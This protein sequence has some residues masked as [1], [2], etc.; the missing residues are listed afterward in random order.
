[1]RSVVWSVVIMLGL[2]GC[3][4][5]KTEPVDGRVKKLLRQMTLEE[6][7]GQ[8]T[9]VTLQ[10]V[11]RT[12]GT[13]GQKHAIDPVKLEEAITQYHVGSILNVWDVAHSLEYWQELITQMQDLATQ[14][15]RL[16]IPIIYGIDAIH[17]A[18]YTLGA[19]LFPQSIAMAATWNPELVRQCAAVTAL[20]VRASGIAWNFNPVMDLGRQPLWPR[21]WET[22]GEDVY[23]AQIMGASYVQGLQGDNIANPEKVAACPKHFL[24]YSFPLT[25]KDRTPAW[26]P[27][28]YLREY[29]LPPFQAALSAGAPTIMVNSS[30]INGIPVHSDP[31][32]LTQILRHEMGFQGFVVSD[33]NDINNLYLRERVAH[34]PKDAVRMAVMAGIDMSMVPYDYS[35]Y[36]LL[37][38]LVREGTVPEKRIDAA[39]GRILKVKYDLGLFDDPY[40]HKELAGRFASPEATALNRQAAGEAITLLKN[41]KNILPLGPQSRILVTGPTA[42]LRSVLNGGWTITWQGNAEELYPHQKPTVLEALT[43]Q[44]PNARVTYLPGVAFDREIDIA[45][46]VRQARKNDV[47]IVCA[48][49]PAYC[50]TPGNIDDLTLSEPQL[51]LVESLA[52]TS[53]PVVLVLVEGRPRL[54]SRIADRVAAVVLAY[55]PG[56]E[57]GLAIADVLLGAVNPSGKLPYSY[58]RYPNSLITYDHKYSEISD[59]NDYDAQWPFGFGLSYTEFQ[60]SDLALHD[61]TIQ[62]G[63]K[64]SASVRVTNV[65]GR[66]GSAVVQLYVSDLVATV[67]PPVKRLKRFAKVGL[68]PGE[69]QLVTFEL[70]TSDLSF[71]GR[72]LKPVVEPGAFLIRVAD[73][74]TRF[75]LVK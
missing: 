20:E 71:I 47:V 17:G 33:W 25:G 52:E 39:V 42:N 75:V 73:L 15:T 40:P 14:K 41:E 56:Q 68:Q 31:Y 30:E 65:G 67:T 7:I 61:T 57:G 46:V 21:L 26:I 22:Y 27:E 28:R 1:M 44:A 50:E 45:G 19:T 11:S 16:G 37:L 54:I 66:A 69:S 32:I 12:Q 36:N 2:M 8:M 4:A 10:T 38:E 34:D 43:T 59:V 72:D 70:N 5:E 60:Y 48:G 55:L 24:G 9:Q 64:L 29:F 6:K 58:P 53:V 62:I 35:F 23:L 18:N 3:S 74:E 63:Q 51:H 13:P 49:E